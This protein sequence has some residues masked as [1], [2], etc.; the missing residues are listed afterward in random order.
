MSITILPLSLKGRRGV[1]TCQ[2]LS[3]LGSTEFFA[4]KGD[5]PEKGVDV[6]MGRG[7]ATFL[8]LYSSITFTVWEEKLSFPLLLFGSSVF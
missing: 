2:K 7:V 3:H 4:R 8:S 5:K 1:K 6:K